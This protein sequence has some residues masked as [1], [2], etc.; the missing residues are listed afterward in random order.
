MTNN[1]QN[2]KKTINE[3]ERFIEIGIALGVGIGVAP[4]I[5]FGVAIRAMRSRRKE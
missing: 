4:G 5:V 2:N 3:A 1:D